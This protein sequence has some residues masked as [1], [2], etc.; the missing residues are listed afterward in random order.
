LFRIVKI[1]SRSNFKPGNTFRG[2]NL[3]FQQKS[4]RPGNVHPEAEN[5]VSSGGSLLLKPGLGQTYSSIDE[6]NHL[7]NMSGSGLGASLGSGLSAVSQKL[8]QLKAEPLKRKPKNIRF[9]L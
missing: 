7:T 8:K 3:R 6:F 9:N 1:P 4:P 2:L 5:Q